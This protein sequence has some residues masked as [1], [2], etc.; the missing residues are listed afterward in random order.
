MFRIQTTGSLST[1]PCL[2]TL[3]I[4]LSGFEIYGQV[5]ISNYRTLRWSPIFSSSRLRI[6]DAKFKHQIKGQKQ[7]TLFEGSCVRMPTVKSSWETALTSET[8]TSG[9][10]YIEFLITNDPKSKLLASSK[11]YNTS[12]ESVDHHLLIGIV[13][14]SY[15][16]VASDSSLVTCQGWSFSSTGFKVSDG[17]C[18][19]YG[20]RFST[21]NRIGM[22][23][24]VDNGTVAYYI[25]GVALGLAYNNIKG[26]HGY[27]IA[28][29]M[30]SINCSV[31]L[32]G[33]LRKPISKRLKNPDW[34]RK[35]VAFARV[36][37]SLCNR[38]YSLSNINQIMNSMKSFE[39]PSIKFLQA[40]YQELTNNGVIML[41]EDPLF[42]SKLSSQQ[43]SSTST[44]TTNTISIVHR[45]SMNASSS[46]LS[47]NI[48]E[49]TSNIVADEEKKSAFDSNID[50][51]KS[52]DDY[53]SSSFSSSSSDDEKKIDNQHEDLLQQKKIQQHKLQEKQYMQSISTSA[54]IP[55][56][57]SSLSTMDNIQYDSKSSS[58]LSSSSLSSSI[59]D[60]PLLSS[61]VFINDF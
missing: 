58:S 14:S 18:A 26:H 43:S 7:A 54:T 27:H 12:S 9:R 37:K 13:P 24:D 34:Y 22:E 8:F 10:H 39:R 41:D 33:T 3:G 16:V 50:E 52:S 57:S 4:I 38:P 32:V 56:S 11:S 49:K 42:T 2:S 21:G 29:S 36:L 48:D 60:A 40:V 53:K 46:L 44:T 15:T 59:P 17:R 30:S 20:Y 5:R 28:I 61:I 25:D 6:N 35:Y 31:L 55:T 23:F 51:K 1:L 47:D 19:A 45:P